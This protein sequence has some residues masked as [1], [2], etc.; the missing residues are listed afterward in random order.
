MTSES[1]RIERLYPAGHRNRHTPHLCPRC[2]APLTTGGRCTRCEGARRADPLTAG[3]PDRRARLRR[4][5]Q[6]GGR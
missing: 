3:F 5:E 1:F 6:I 2:A 4:M